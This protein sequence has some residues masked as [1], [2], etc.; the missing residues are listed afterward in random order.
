MR[1]LN[2]NLPVTNFYDL[3]FLWLEKHEG[4]KLELTLIKWL[5]S[6]KEIYY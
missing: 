2:E 3:D 4:E 1:F 6:K 5:I